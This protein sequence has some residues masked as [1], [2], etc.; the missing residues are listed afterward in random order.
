MPLYKVLLSF[1]CNG[2][3]SLDWSTYVLAYIYQVA[4]KSEDYN[5]IKDYCDLPVEL[6]SSVPV[7]L[8]V[9]TCFR[10][11]NAIR[12]KLVK[13]F[14]A[15]PEGQIQFFERFVDTNYLY[16]NF[17]FR[18]SEYLKNKKT[19][20]AE[21]FGHCILYLGS[22]LKMDMA[23]CNQEYRTIMSVTPDSSI[24]PWPIGRMVSATLLQKYFIEGGSID[25]IDGLI[26]HYREIAYEYNN[27]LANGV[28]EFEMYI[29]I[30]LVLLERYDSLISLVETA[31]ESYR[32]HDPKHEGFSFM[33][34]HQNQ[35]PMHFLEYARYKCGK[36]MKNNFH[37]RWERA[38]DNYA[39]TFDDYQYLIL[40]NF[41]LYD[42]YH[43]SGLTSN[44]IQYYQAAMDLSAHAGYKFYTIYFQL[45]YPNGSYKNTEEAEKELQLSGFNPSCFS[46]HGIEM[47]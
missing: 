38:L 29:M 12:E 7:R 43:A 18:I 27:Y 4:Y 42:Y 37:L 47:P 14:A 22:F 17:T 1:V 34:Q 40:L 36:K 11:P 9:G 8:A 45:K 2:G 26:N 23:G 46:P 13:Q 33:H 32:I 35:I 19:A 30:A 15:H 3:K 6:I 10:K 41:F 24:Y 28:I 31:L 20:E 16:D 44:A 5:G 25:D 39:S 21:L